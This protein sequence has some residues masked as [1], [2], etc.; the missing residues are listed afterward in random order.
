MTIYA[1]KEP[2]CPGM[3]NTEGGYCSSCD[4]AFERH[5]GVQDSPDHF[6]DAKE[7]REVEV[8]GKRAICLHCKREMNITAKGLCYTCYQNHGSE[9]PSGKRGGAHPKTTAEPTRPPHLRERPEATRILLGMGYPA[10][11]TANR[12][13][14]F[15]TQ[16]TASELV[17]AFIKA[18]D[19]Q[20]LTPEEEPVPVGEEV[21]ASFEVEDEESPEELLPAKKPKERFFAVEIKTEE[22]EKLASY[23]ETA[24]KNSRRTPGDWI[25]CCVEAYLEE[26]KESD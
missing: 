15:S 11:E 17:N 1:C 23:I 3:T 4:E 24:A 6:P 26:R 2:G 9:Y 5:F 19:P 14:G 22:D 21:D 7:K 16:L 20:A 18:I 8:M 13:P 25:L 10:V 12:L